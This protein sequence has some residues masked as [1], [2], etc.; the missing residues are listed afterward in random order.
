MNFKTVLRK[1]LKRGLTTAGVLPTKYM[2]PNPFKIIEFEELLARVTFHRNDLVL[3][4]GCGAGVQDFLIGRKAGKVVGI[5]ISETQIERANTLARD[6][7]SGLD[8]QFICTAVERAEFCDNQFD[9]V[10]SFCV[11]EHIP[12]YEAVLT[13]VFRV[14]KSGGLLLL[15]VDSL[16]TID[17][18]ELLA[19]HKTDHSVHKYFRPDEIKSLLECVG[20]QRVS[21]YPVFRSPCAKRLFEK[22]IRNGF[23]FHRYRKFWSYLRLRVGEWRYRRAESGLFLCVRAVKPQ[24]RGQN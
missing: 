22:S 11:L 6:Y 7:G 13:A 18:L 23:H 4:L 8:L 1:W 16:A 3:D 5:D 24:C 21:V 14:L 10:V 19:K 20:F 12:N 2:W 15:S 17:D 9:K